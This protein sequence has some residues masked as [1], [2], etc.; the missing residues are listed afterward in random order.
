MEFVTWRV[1]RSLGRMPADLED[2][3][4]AD[5]LRFYEYLQL[6]EMLEAE[7]RPF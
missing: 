5:L 4:Y 1:A 2:L 7:R 6:T 3:P